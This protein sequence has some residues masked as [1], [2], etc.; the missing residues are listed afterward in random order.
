M[1]KSLQCLSVG[2][3]EAAVEVEQEQAITQRVGLSNR[4]V[5]QLHRRSRGAETPLH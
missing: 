3:F 4:A 1:T 2:L 5:K